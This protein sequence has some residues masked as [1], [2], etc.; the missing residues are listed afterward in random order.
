MFDLRRLGLM[1]TQISR[2]LDG[3]VSERRLRDYTEGLSSPSHYRGELLLKLWCAQTGCAV[4]DAPR[5][6]VVLRT[7]PGA[8][9]VRA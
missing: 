6:P 3:A 7:M 8:R 5:E 9:V 4:E 1:P 2:M